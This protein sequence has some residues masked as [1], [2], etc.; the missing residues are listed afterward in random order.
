MIRMGKGAAAETLRVLDNR[1]PVNLRNTEVVA[2][3][4]KRFPADVA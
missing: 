2:D 4:R 3:Y 1:L